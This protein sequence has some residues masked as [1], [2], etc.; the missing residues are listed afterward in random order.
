MSR[1]GHYTGVK[2]RVNV[3]TFCWDQKIIADCSEVTVSQGLTVINFE[4]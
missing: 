3:W 1:G 4:N 2:I